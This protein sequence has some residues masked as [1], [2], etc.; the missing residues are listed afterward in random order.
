MKKISTTALSKILDVNLSLLFKRLEDERFIVRENKSWVLTRRGKEVGGE[1]MTTKNYGVYIVWPDA[2]N[3]IKD[4]RKFQ[5]SE[6]ITSSK[7]AEELD[8]S[9]RKLNRIFNEFGWIEKGIKGWKITPLGM[10]M[11]GV[12]KSHHKSATTYIIWPVDILNGMQYLPDAGLIKLENSDSKDNNKEYSD[13]RKKWPADIRTTD[14]HYVRSRGECIIDNQLYNYGLTHAYERQL[15]IKEKVIS[16][17]YIPSNNGGKSVYIEFWG[18]E[19]D[20]GYE[21]RKKEKQKIYKENKLNLIEINEE[22]LN[23]LDDYLPKKLLEFNIR[24]E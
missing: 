21:K 8:I 12:E 16:D 11:G 10:K 2:F 13:Y 22:F 6:L 4:S 7:L 9:A 19:E 15:P 1:M 24:V 20:E 18:I 23:N 5:S 17:F 14:G 3:P